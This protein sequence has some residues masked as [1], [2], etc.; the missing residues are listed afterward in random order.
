MYTRA[1]VRP[2][3]P[4]FALGVTTGALG[5]PDWELAVEQHRAYCAALER[6]GLEVI[7]LE[8][9]PGLPDGCFVEDAAVVVEDVAVCTIPGALTRRGEVADL[10]AA[11]EQYMPVAPL[12]PPATL[13]GGDVLVVGQRMYVGVSARS[14]IHGAEQLGR[15]ALDKGY[16]WTPVPVD[17]G[18]HLKSSVNWVDRYVLVT[19]AGFADLP[20]FQD[21]E[22]L[23][24]EPDEDYACNCLN[25]NGTIIMA[26]GYPATRKL[27]DSLGMPV[28]ELDMSEFRKMDGGLT[29][30]S[31]RF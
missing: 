11:L 15:V 28:I 3:G 8:A 29:C 31:V 30:L 12:T 18:L 14:N 10:A 27:V 6:C 1:I 25:I 23:V 24:T 19:T 4:D 16:A 17:A 5:A 22:I 21:F 20:A 13:D 7:E 26:A 2:P 9:L